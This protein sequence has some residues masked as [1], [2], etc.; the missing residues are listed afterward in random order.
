MSIVG[1]SWLPPPNASLRTPCMQTV[2][3]RTL[4]VISRQH[5]FHLQSIPVVATK[6]FPPVRLSQDVPPQ[7]RKPGVPAGHCA[8]RRTKKQNAKA[9]ADQ[10]W[11]N[12][13]LRL[14][15]NQREL[16]K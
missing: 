5:V 13:T 10:I 8:K 15:T 3:M 14:G 11:L 12:G 6:Q 7:L 2:R 4:D 16:R 9:L 1:T